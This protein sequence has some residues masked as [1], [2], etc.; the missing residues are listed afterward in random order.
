MAHTAVRLD[1]VVLAVEVID[2]CNPAGLGFDRIGI[3]EIPAA[4]VV[5]QDNLR[6]PRLPLIL[7]HTGAQAVGRQAITV[8]AHEPP[9]LHLDEAA[10][11]SVIIHAR[12]EVP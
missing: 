4:A 12:E 2:G 7:A 3:A 6:P 9:V 1:P 11:C 10:G 5:P 8:N